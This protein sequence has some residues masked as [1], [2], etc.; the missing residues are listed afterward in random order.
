MGRGVL[1]RFKTI[2]HGGTADAASEE[3][4]RLY[5]CTACNRTYISTAMESCPECNQPVRDVPN[6]R[7]LGQS[8]AY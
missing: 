4:A 1:G 6:E 5:E 8:T 2:V 3:S 7:D